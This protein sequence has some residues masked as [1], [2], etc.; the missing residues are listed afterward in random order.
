MPITPPV[1][2]TEISA[3]AFGV[4]VANQLNALVPTAWTAL[5]YAPS[6]GGTANPAVYRRVGDIVYVQ[7][8]I[9]WNGGTVGAGTNVFATMPSGFRPPAARRFP[10]WYNNTGTAIRV[11]VEANGQ[12]YIDIALSASHSYAIS[13]IYSTTA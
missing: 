3:S 13:M 12:A 9:I 2:D 10:G 5:A 6:W 7:G 8:E 11:S 4:P 1:V